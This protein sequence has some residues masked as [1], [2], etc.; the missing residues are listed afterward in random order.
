M[1]NVVSLKKERP[2]KI[3]SRHNSCVSSGHTSQKW[4]LILKIFLV[5]LTK[6]MTISNSCSGIQYYNHHAIELHFLVFLS[7]QLK[8]HT[9]KKR[10]I[11]FTINIFRFSMHTYLFQLL[12]PGQN[13]LLIFIFH[14]NVSVTRNSVNMLLQGARP[15]YT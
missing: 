13:R 10:S 15:V 8:L 11:S 4:D 3:K 7:F 5:K 12:F 9:V 1:K 2:K 6:F 14:S